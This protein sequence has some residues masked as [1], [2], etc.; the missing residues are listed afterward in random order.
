M[1][2]G[3]RRQLALELVEEKELAPYKREEEA[4]VRHKGGKTP[5][6]NYLHCCLYYHN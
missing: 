3:E 6:L 1:V 5:A 4:R 2:V